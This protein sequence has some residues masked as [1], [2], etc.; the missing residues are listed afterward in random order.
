MILRKPYAFLIKNFKL[1]HFILLFLMAYLIIKTISIQRYIKTFINSV[2]AERVLTSE[3]ITWWL[4]LAIILIILISGVVYLLMRYK[5]KP[6]TIYF[7]NISVYII[8]LV[9]FIYVYNTLSSLEIK[10]LD[11]RTLILTRDILNMMLLSLGTTSVLMFI[12]GLGFD[13]KKFNFAEDLNELNIEVTDNEEFE[14]SSPINTD[15]I[16]RNIRKRKRLFKYFIL[17]NKF[18]FILGFVFIIFV[19]ALNLFLNTFVYKSTYNENQAFRGNKFI[20]NITS[21]YLTNTSYNNKIISDKDSSYVVIKYKINKLNNSSENYDP[22]DFKLLISYSY[23]SVDTK[24]CS[25]FY[26]LGECYKEKFYDQN[27][28]YILI[29]KIN[30]SEQNKKMVLRYLDSLNYKVGSFDA[31]YKKVKLS[32]K[33]L[34]TLK[35]EDSKNLGDNLSFDNSLFSGISL[36]I[37]SY[38]LKP[39]FDY[40]YNA[41][42]NNVCNNYP[43]VI[44]S[45]SS[46][47][48]EKLIMRLDYS[49]E[50]NLN[51][52]S[53][54]K[55][56]SDFG[57]ISYLKDNM[58][59]KINYTDLTPS[60]YDGTSVYLELDSKIKDASSISFIFNIRNHEYTYKIL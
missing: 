10:T 48:S 11:Q 22:N 17:E 49:Y 41:C 58:T 33:D 13:I 60:N 25:Q 15:K 31:K 18:Y 54:A 3:Y 20:F 5:K 50:N 53:A 40:T 23:Y 32:P 43:G 45:V 36:K 26:D 2:T 19:I 21:S 38:E 7:I 39:R 4:F 9:A 28:D 35:E 29:F 51:N 56:I 14:L 12:R 6:K 37:N 27:K 44:S 8:I 55:L 16:L 47:L 42:I 57:T 59:Y 34:T 52:I 46:S 30:K 24:L 1:I